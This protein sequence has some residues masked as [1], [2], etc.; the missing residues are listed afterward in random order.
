MGLWKPGLV[1]WWGIGLAVGPG[2]WVAGWFEL[3]GSSNWL[4]GICDG[5]QC[6]SSGG[7]W[8]CC[9]LGVAGKERGG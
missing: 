5:V 9:G 8:G 3:V 6:G 4:C 7:G 2:G 1:G